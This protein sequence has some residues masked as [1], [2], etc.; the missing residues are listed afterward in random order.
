MAENSFYA[1]LYYLCVNDYYSS[2]DEYSGYWFC[3]KID[4][5]NSQLLQINIYD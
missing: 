4:D 3:R 2:F 1:V 5:F